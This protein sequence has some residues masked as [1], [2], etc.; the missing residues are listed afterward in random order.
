MAARRGPRRPLRAGTCTRVADRCTRRRPRAHNAGGRHRGSH[1]QGAPQIA[2]QH[3]RKGLRDER[4]R[5]DVHDL[6]GM[7]III[8]PQPVLPSHSKSTTAATGCAGLGAGEAASSE[9]SAMAACYR[10]ADRT[11]RVRHRQWAHQGLPPASHVEW[12]LIAAEHAA[13]P[14]RMDRCRRRCERR[15]QPLIG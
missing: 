7:R 9:R 1:S 13:P 10:A 11:Q 2:L 12:V 8:T 5:E 14:P 3:M 6:L 4:M 15:Q